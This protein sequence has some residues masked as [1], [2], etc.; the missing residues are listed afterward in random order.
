MPIQKTEFP[1]LMVI[2]PIVF[3]DSR[4]YFFE[5]Y[6]QKV[7]EAEGLRFNWVQDNQSKSTYGVV[8]GLHYQL[9]PHSQAKLVRVFSGSVLDVAVDLRK[10]SPTYGKSFCIELSDQNRLQLLIPRG[11]AHGFSVL[12]PSAEVFYKCDQL[13]SKAAEA[14]IIYNDPVLKIDWKIPA[15]DIILSDKDTDHP[16]FTESRHNF[17][18]EG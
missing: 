13:Y 7:F 2:E 17:E 4:G 6:N 12:T 14:S 10:G 1:G 9:N 5:S 18:F 11:F 8:R 15:Q 3:E 16:V